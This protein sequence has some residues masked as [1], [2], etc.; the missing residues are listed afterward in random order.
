M[1]F[2]WRAEEVCMNIEEYARKHEKYLPAKLQRETL[3]RLCELQSGDRMLDIG[4]AEGSTLSMLRGVL[5]DGV[6]L[7]GM[8]LSETRIQKAKGK[9][10]PDTSFCV[11]NIETIPFEADFFSAVT[12]SQVIEH[13]PNDG[14]AL[15]EIARVL[16]N[17][18]FFQIDTV[19]KKK[20]AKYFYKSPC[21]WALDPTHLR[22]YTDIDSLLALFPKT[23]K[24][25][26]AFLKPVVRRFNTLSFLSFLP[27]WVKI[28]IWG[29]YNLFIIG[30]KTI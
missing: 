24:V 20:W 9:L 30:V 3:E 17:G 8:D 21:G 23:L 26:R 5:H 28:R 16:K 18:G 14:E 12:C 19:Y 15:Q 2:G 27:D 4:C 7:Y 22:E 6:L 13:V 29:Y 11:G 25:E 10:I 1:T